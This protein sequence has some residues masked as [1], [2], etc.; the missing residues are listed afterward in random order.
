ML[1]AQSQKLNTEP[2]PTRST[3]PAGTRLLE[4][5][6]KEREAKRRRLEAISTTTSTAASIAQA[7]KASIS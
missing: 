4:K 5:L 3:L 2:I 6:E 7:K 1:S